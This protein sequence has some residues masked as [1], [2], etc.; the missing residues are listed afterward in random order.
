MPQA[1]PARSQDLT[2]AVAVRIG[3]L[4]HWDAE[5]EPQLAACVQAVLDELNAMLDRSQPTYTLVPGLADGADRLMPS[6]DRIQAPAVTHLAG[7]VTVALRHFFRSFKTESSKRQFRTLFGSAKSEAPPNADRLRWEQ[8][9]RD[10]SVLLAIWNRDQVFHPDSAA[11][12][13][14]YALETAGRTVYWID[15][16]TRKIRCYDNDDGFIDCIWHLNAYN[17]ER[18]AVETVQDGTRAEM[19]ALEALAYQCQLPSGTLEPLE[20]RVIPHFVRASRRAVHWQNLHV[21]AGFFIYS[22]AAVAVANAIVVSVLGWDRRWIF[23]EVGEMGAILLV[24]GIS[25]FWEWLRR[26]IDY[27]FL[28]ERLRASIFL[29]VAG[30]ACE[31][32]SSDQPVSWMVRALESIRDLPLA[33]LQPPNLRPVKQFIREGW[34]EHQR[35]YYADRSE[36]FDTWHKLL[37]AAGVILFLATAVA[38][39]AHALEWW[40]RYEKLIEAASAILPAA[41]AAVAGFRAF[42]EYNRTSLQYAA[43]KKSL[44]RLADDLDKAATPEALI[45]LLRDADHAIIREHEGWRFLVDV[46]EPRETI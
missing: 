6:M 13:I 44:Q 20:A 21:A 1:A 3:I 30:L 31:A 32:P 25:E 22:M 2:I 24:V 12:L 45:Q 40:E 15:P 9:I 10:C 11:P 43:M 38:A 34:L 19:Q 42:R 7:R 8:A 35:K 17:A 36:Q 16:A 26:W 29:F 37:A 33:P 41:G 23:A 5:Q 18:I 27:R 4:G 14:A 28:A 46:H 39:L